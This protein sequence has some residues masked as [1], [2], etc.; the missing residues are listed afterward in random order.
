VM[1]GM[2]FFFFDVFLEVV[3]FV[4]DVLVI[5]TSCFALCA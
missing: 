1:S 5:F 2:V 3:F 4:F